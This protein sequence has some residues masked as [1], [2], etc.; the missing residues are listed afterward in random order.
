MEKISSL[1]T[2]ISV[3]GLADMNIMIEIFTYEIRMSRVISREPNSY[4]EILTKDDL[5]I[6][7]NQCLPLRS[8]FVSF[9]SKTSQVQSR[10]NTGLKIRF[11]NN[12]KKH[13]ALERN[14]TQ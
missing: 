8:R 4:E 10:E 12:W 1:V 3:T 2:E 13:S 7:M 6:H 11:A 9:S 5:L 14:T